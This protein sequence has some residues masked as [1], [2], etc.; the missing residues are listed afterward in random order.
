MRDGRE[1]TA[2]DLASVVAAAA[3]NAN[4]FLK[5]HAKVTDK[6]PEAQEEKKED[7]AEAEATSE[8][9]KE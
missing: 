1:R 7:A 4:P 6:K 2:W 9:T 5:E 3:F 8:E